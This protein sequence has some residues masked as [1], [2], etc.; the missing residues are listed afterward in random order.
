MIIEKFL[1]FCFRLVEPLLPKNMRAGFFRVIILGTDNTLTAKYVKPKENAFSVGIQRYEVNQGQVYRQGR[2]RTPTLFYISTQ[3]NPISLRPNDSTGLLTS[4][5]NHERMESH[6][7]REALASFD[8][9][10]L[11]GKTPA[12]ILL[13]A[14]I[15]VGVMG[16]YQLDELKT[17]IEIT[18]PSSTSSVDSLGR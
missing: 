5:E 18:L 4:L 6:I 3:A 9:N 10:I 8:D 16:W 7:A 2:F 17:L 14:I 11:S 1:E 13:I 15:A 12:I